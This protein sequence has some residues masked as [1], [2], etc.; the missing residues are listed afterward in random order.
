MSELFLLQPL[1]PGCS[2]LD[3]LDKIQSFFGTLKEQWEEGWNLME[4]KGAYEP[5][6]TINER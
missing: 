3:Q 2:D 4:I 6:G 5:T 1:L